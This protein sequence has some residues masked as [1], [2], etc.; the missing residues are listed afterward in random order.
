MHDLTGIGK[1]ALDKELDKKEA[2]K[3]GPGDT[4]RQ[5]RQQQQ[6]ESRCLSKIRLQKERVKSVRV[7][8]RCARKDRRH[9]TRTSSSVV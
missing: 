5:K 4:K 6:D 7:S 2:R 3:K 9:C 1:L 8:K